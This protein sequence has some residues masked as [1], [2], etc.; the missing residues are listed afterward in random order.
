MSLVE[1]TS[2]CLLLAALVLA[3]ALSQATGA[4]GMT[5]EEHAIEKVSAALVKYELKYVTKLTSNICGTTGEEGTEVK[6]LIKATSGRF[7]LLRTYGVTYPGVFSR[8]QTILCK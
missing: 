2:K 5:Y 1:S 8:A 3:P 4:R 7:V 6:V